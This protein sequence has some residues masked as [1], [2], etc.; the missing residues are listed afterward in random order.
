MRSGTKKSNS[1]WELTLKFCLAPA[2][3]SLTTFRQSPRA[4]LTI[5]HHRP[6]CFPKCIP[7][8]SCVFFTIV[9]ELFHTVDTPQKMSIPTRKLNDGTEFPLLGY[10][11]GTALFKRGNLDELD[12]S[13]VD[14]ISTAIKLG[15]SH[16]E[17]CRRSALASW[18]LLS[19]R[20][21]NI[22]DDLC[23]GRA[24]F[25]YVTKTKVVVPFAH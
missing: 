21:W 25:A 6:K 3:L 23:S 16:C 5:C 24:S 20:L 13:T 19:L 9:G 4:H 11:T 12:Q 15:R 1:R 8:F 14:A 7:R 18:S 17:V 2:L 10:G 22:K